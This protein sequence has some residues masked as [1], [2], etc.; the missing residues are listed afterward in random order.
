M[1]CIKSS[2]ERKYEFIKACFFNV[3]GL[4]LDLKNEFHCELAQCL[5]FQLRWLGTCGNYS[6]EIIEMPGKARM[7]SPE[8]QDDFSVF[9]GNEIA[10]TKPSK[11]IDSFLSVH[12][13]YLDLNVIRKIKDRGN[14]EEVTRY[15]IAQ[16]IKKNQHVLYWMHG[17]NMAFYLQE[18]VYPCDQKNIFT[19][20]DMNEKYVDSFPK[21]PVND[22]II[23]ERI[24]KQAINDL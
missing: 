3:Y 16:E 2:N 4:E 19:R 18:V 9:T 1:D 24:L 17:V 20:K 14:C 21:K 11:T 13:L 15:F 8:L 12:D 5:F 23:K 22:M 10:H 6:H 7:Y